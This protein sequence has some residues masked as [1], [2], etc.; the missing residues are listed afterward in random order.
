MLNVKDAARGASGDS[1]D[2]RREPVTSKTITGEPE[3]VQ[4]PAQDIG[5]G[6]AGQ[7]QDEGEDDGGRLTTSSGTSMTRTRRPRR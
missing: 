1:R 2:K 5:Q 4:G 3:S 7:G 6:L